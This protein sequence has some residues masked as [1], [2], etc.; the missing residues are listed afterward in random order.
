MFDII[1]SLSYNRDF[2]SREES[3]LIIFTRGAYATIAIIVSP[4]GAFSKRQRAECL[5]IFKSIFRGAYTTIAI[6]VSPLGAFSKG[7]RAECLE[8]FKSILRGAY[9]TIAMIVSPLGVLKVSTF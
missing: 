6:I 1:K 8:I 9:A 2:M 3:C 5:E 7:Q 4:L